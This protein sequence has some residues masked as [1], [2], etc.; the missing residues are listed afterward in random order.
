MP[1]SSVDAVASKLQVNCT[2]LIVACAVGGWLPG[3]SMS[4]P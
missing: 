1:L 4:S 3:G 2:Q